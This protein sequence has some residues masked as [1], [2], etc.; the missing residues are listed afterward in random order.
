MPADHDEPL[1]DSESRFVWERGDVTVTYTPPEPEPRSL[2]SDITRL[3]TEIHDR[4]EQLTALLT[5]ELKVEAKR[6]FPDAKALQLVQETD[7]PFWAAG[8][9]YNETGDPN[10]GDHTGPNLLN[11]DDDAQ[12]K[13][14]ELASELP[15]TD[16]EEYARELTL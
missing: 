12:D 15:C 6:L 4:E 1:G 2:Q 16:S 8:G 14:A 13:L 3:W 9:V 10:S 11:D 5:A 7:G